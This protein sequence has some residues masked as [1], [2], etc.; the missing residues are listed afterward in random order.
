MNVLS[1]PKRRATTRPAAFRTF[2]DR[3]V[4]RPSLKD[5]GSAI[6]DK[7]AKRVGPYYP[8]TQ[9][10]KPPHA[11][12]PSARSQTETSPKPFLED[13]RLKPMK[14]PHI[15]LPSAHSQLGMFALPVPRES[16]ATTH[17]AAFR[18]FTARDVRPSCTM[19][20]T[21]QEGLAAQP[22]CLQ[23]DWGNRLKG[24]SKLPNAL[25]PSAHSQTET[26]RSV[27]S[28]RGDDTHRPTVDVSA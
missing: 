27:S 5:A 8:E 25:L 17:P 23:K 20:A 21:K 24:G 15:L 18:I 2:T 11:L 1:S 12:L 6:D 3:D 7:K 26:F 19:L 13:M 14:P 28:T 16:C 22:C 10:M 4:R 9:K